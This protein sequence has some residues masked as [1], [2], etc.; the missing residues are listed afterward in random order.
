MHMSS[1]VLGIIYLLIASLPAFLI[2]L[3]RR[4][5]QGKSL[6]LVITVMCA[7]LTEWVL[8]NAIMHFCR[9]D[10]AIIF[11]HEAKY[12]GI[13]YIPVLVFMFAL[14]YTSIKLPLISKK[15][16]L[17][18]ILPTIT[19]FI[20]ATNPFHHLFRTS[21]AIDIGQVVKIHSENAWWYNVHAFYSYTLIGL[22]VLLFLID[23]LRQPRVY[24]SRPGLIL[25]GITVPTFINLLFD[26]G[27]INMKLPV[28]TTPWP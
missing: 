12:I 16:G 1:T 27:F 26:S 25:L 6:S 3:Y 28:E 5:Y 9:A 22:T 14:E 17:L 19:V 8:C 4:Q 7:L 11:W 21:L 15:P 24:R 2:F 13:A 20:V 23:F 10:Y 18:F